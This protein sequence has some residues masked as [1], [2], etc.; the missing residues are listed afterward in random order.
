MRKWVAAVDLF[1]NAMALFLMCVILMRPL[2]NPPAEEAKAEPPGN[3]IVSIVWPPGDADVDL[4]VDGPGEP[5]PIGYSNKGGLLWN[6]LRDDLGI[7]PDLTN[8]NYENA[9]SRGVIGGEYT[10]GLH[11]Y[12][13]PILPQEVTVE[14]SINTGTPG[15]ASMKPLVTTQVKLTKAGQEKTAIRFWLNEDGTIRP[16]S[17]NNVFKSLRSAKK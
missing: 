14:V 4:W 2:L 8:V 13:C 7:Q 6:L 11:C 1:L 16:G 9:Y 10:I 5:V 3:M 12:R 15:K 17:Q